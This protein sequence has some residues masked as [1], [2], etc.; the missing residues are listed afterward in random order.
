MHLSP[1]AASS[2]HSIAAAAQ[3]LRLQGCQNSNFLLALSQLRIQECELAC[4][5]VCAGAQIVSGFM[6][7]PEMCQTLVALESS[8]SH[9]NLQHG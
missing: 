3:E 6:S 1:A 8:M 7:A 9:K 4:A 5:Q 2:L